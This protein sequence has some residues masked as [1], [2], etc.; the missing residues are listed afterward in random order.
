MGYILSKFTLKQALHFITLA[1][2]L[3]NSYTKL[4]QAAIATATL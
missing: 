2:K 3:F 4:F 1:I